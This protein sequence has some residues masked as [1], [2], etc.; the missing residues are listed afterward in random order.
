MMIDGVPHLQEQISSPEAAD[1]FLR[2]V[3]SQAT[4]ADANDVVYSFE[5][6]KD[7]DAEPD[8]GRITTKVFALNFADDEFYRDSLQILQRDIPQ[9]RQ[10]QNRG[11]A[12]L[13]RFGRTL[14]NGASGSVE[15]TGPYIHEMV[16]HALRP[17]RVGIFLVASAT[18]KSKTMKERHE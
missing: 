3:K 9:V 6:S 16:G 12:H 4:G 10:A 15:R 8:L 11:A 2:G 14:F 13:S 1:A 17:S 7:F 5:S 18:S